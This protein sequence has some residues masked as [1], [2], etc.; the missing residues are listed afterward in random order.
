M[1]EDIKRQL[2][3]LVARYEL[4]PEL[5]CDIYV[6]GNT[7]KHLIE[8]FLAEEGFQDFAV[9]EIETINIPMAKLNDMKLNDSHRSRVIAL[10]LEMQNQ[11]SVTP[12]HLTGIVD[13]DFDWL[14]EQH[15]ECEY[16]LFTDYT[17]M[18]MYLFNEKVITK[19][20]HLVVG[21]S[22][23]QAHD[24]LSHLSPILENLFL[25]RATNEALQLGMS[26][27]SFERCCK[28]K[29]QAIEF[30][31]T[32]FI[33]RYLNKN[34]Q[35]AQKTLFINKREALR[36]QSDS[37]LEKRCK[38]RGHDFID[39]LHWYI[40]HFLPKARKNAYNTEVIRGSL[41]GC[42]EIE[43]LKQEELFKRLLERLD[44]TDLF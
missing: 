30:Q 18:E 41:L 26:W 20:L 15:Y 35:L 28:L 19:F 36:L 21:L 9:Y 10:A 33:E 12:K 3:E 1:E 13:K 29:N 42:V 44:R 34:N 31:T 25:T 11:L 37:L 8:W 27:L 23:I 17:S 22:K 39:V 6:E 43:D 24:M 38:I 7:D 14:F 4:E 32:T 40:K 5:C 2:D 16:L